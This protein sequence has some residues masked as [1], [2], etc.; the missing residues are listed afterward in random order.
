MYSKENVRTIMTSE[1]DLW[2]KNLWTEDLTPVKIFQKNINFINEKYKN[3]PFEENQVLLTTY[4]LN[5]KINIGVITCRDMSCLNENKLFMYLASEQEAKKI[6]PR[7]Q[8]IVDK[9]EKLS[10]EE[11]IFSFSSLTNFQ[12]SNNFENE[13]M[14]NVDAEGIDPNNGVQ[15]L[16]TQEFDNNF[17][18]Q[19][20]KKLM[21]EAYDFFLENKDA[22]EHAEYEIINIT[23]NNK[24]FGVLILYDNSTM[25]QV[26]FG[27]YQEV[28]NMTKS[29]MESV[30]NGISIRQNNTGSFAER[31]ELK[32]KLRKKKRDD[33]R[34]RK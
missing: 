29:I 11:M 13:E 23:K 8:R 9:K 17:T 26:M 27:T 22:T 21:S 33:R 1:D 28:S 20:I 18:E 2:E 3:E 12:S 30:K 15:T 4:P 34:R 25:S 6:V 16:I 32:K 14:V 31:C 24:E 7:I 19:E 10:S 5:E